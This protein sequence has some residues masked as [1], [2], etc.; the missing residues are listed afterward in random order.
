MD[1]NGPGRHYIGPGGPWF[2]T[3]NALINNYVNNIHDTFADDEGHSKTDIWGVTARIDHDFSG[4][5]FTSLTSYRDVDADIDNLI[6]GGNELVNLRLSSG[7]APAIL[8]GTN[9][10]VDQSETFTQEFRITSSGDGDWEWVAG[11]YYLQEEAYRNER[12]PIGV[13]A[14]DGMGGSIPVVPIGPGGNEMDNT[15]DSYAVFGQVTYHATDRLRITVGGRQ[16]WEEKDAHVIGTPNPLAP[17]RDFNLRL[18]EDWSKFTPK[19]TIDYQIT[20]DAFVYFSYSEGFKSGGFPGGGNN[21]LIA[22]TGF[23]PEEAILYELGTKTEWFDNRLRLNL[24]VFYTD[25]TDLQI[26]QLL[27]PNDAPAG[28]PGSLITQNAADAEIKGA[29]LEFSWVPGENWLVQGSYTYLDS[30]FSGFFIPSGF[31]SPGGTPPADRTG[32]PLRNAPENAYNVLVRYDY[33]TRGGWGLRLQA[34]YRHKDE[35]FQDPDVLEFA[36]VDEYDVVDL[37]ATLMTPDGH[38][39]VT[40]WAKNAFDEDYFLHNFPLQG[41]GV[42]TPALPRTWG[43]TVNWQN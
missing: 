12:G 14:A 33:T 41:S 36:K 26:L 21:E 27:V 35:V 1:Q 18:D 24:A 22:S 28:N 40:A 16:T 7:A 43:I 25:Y 5:T 11:V 20:D 38:W 32:N 29:E 34:D 31:R 15:T 10:Y 42:A 2:L 8:G 4:F 17:G 9:P 3:E 6:L 13:F 23:D 30:E 37:R 39:A 19:A